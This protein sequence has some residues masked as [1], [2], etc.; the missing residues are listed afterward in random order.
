MRQA[1]KRAKAGDGAKPSV[2][3]SSRSNESSRVRD[4][5]TRL[6]E[7]QER[8]AK[9]LKRE[10]EALDQQTATGEILGVIASSPTNLQSVLDAVAEKAARLCN[11]EDAA[12]IL[13][14]A[15]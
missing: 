15:D 12:V 6:A 10:A 14:G 8:E 13:L 3:K 2:A 7:A 11:A 5:E 9:A 4:L 1:G